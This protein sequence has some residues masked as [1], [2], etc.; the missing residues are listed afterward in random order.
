M[1]NTAIGNKIYNKLFHGC[2]GD[3]SEFLPYSLNDNAYCNMWFALLLEVN[4][5]LE[6]LYSKIET[7]PLAFAAARP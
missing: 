6:R 2:I 7:I 1:W 3:W 5:P 4:A